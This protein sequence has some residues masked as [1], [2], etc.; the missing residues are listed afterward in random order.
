MRW[1]AAA[2]APAAGDEPLPQGAAHLRCEPGPP[3]HRTVMP[4][5]NGS[6][7]QPTRRCNAGASCRVCS[8]PQAVQL[9]CLLDRDLDICE[10]DP[11][12]VVIKDC[13]RTRHSNLHVWCRR[14]AWRPPAAATLRRRIT[15][16]HSWLQ[17]PA[18]NSSAVRTLASDNRRLHL[19]LRV[20]TTLSSRL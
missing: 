4:G 11:A 16:S 7:W 8:V 19:C 10:L 20:G 14:T 1:G 12:A 13:I 15:L 2:G 9:C 3:T 17:Y 18:T 6:Q 5:L